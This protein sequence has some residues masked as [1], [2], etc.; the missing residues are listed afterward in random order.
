[1]TELCVLLSVPIAITTCGVNG[2]KNQ[3]IP[4]RGDY[5]F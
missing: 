2:K 1:M 3:V 4:K 5:T